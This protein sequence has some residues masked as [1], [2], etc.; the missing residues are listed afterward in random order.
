M[1]ILEHLSEPGLT[2]RSRL[3]LRADL[4]AL[5]DALGR[6]YAQA[7]FRPYPYRYRV[8]QEGLEVFADVELDWWQFWSR[9]E[10]LYGTLAA[11]VLSLEGQASSRLVR[12][13]VRM[14]FE[15]ENLAVVHHNGQGF[16]R[17]A[18]LKQLA[19]HS[20]PGQP[21]S[22]PARARRRS[23]RKRSSQ[24]RKTSTQIPET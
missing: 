8:C 5:E 13:V 24:S 10:A 3:R 1:V 7:Y 16:G 17:K 12:A 20:L 19:Q 18:Y 14:A 15:F 11:G 23:K 6:Q 2:D 4:L 22:R 9:E 21:A